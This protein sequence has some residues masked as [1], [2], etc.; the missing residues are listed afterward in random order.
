MYVCVCGGISVTI[1]SL[2]IATS[3]DYQQNN[4]EK[5]KERNINASSTFIFSITAQI[6]DLIS[7]SSNENRAA[8]DYY[9][10]R[11]SI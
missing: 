1:L 4:R 11:S 9:Y 2:G 8:L 10:C 5:E 7:A 6:K 3:V